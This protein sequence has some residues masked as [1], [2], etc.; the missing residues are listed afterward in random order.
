MFTVKTIDFPGYKNLKNNFNIYKDIFLN[1]QIIAFRNANIDFNMQTQIMNLLGDNL[2]WYP[3]SY[4]QNPSDYIEDH[5]KHMN[6]NNIATKNSIMLGWHQE[7]VASNNGA[8]VSGLWNMTLFN[9]SPDTGKTYFVDMAKFYKN[10]PEEDK[11]FLN[12]C[13]A[14]VKLEDNFVLYDL[15]SLHWITGERVLRTYFDNEVIELFEVDGKSPSNLEIIKFN[16]LCKH[17][18]SEINFNENIRMQHIWQKGDLLITDLFKLAHAVSGGFNK[19]ERKLEG[20]FGK[21]EPW[22][23]L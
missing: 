20:M 5:H 6:S 7:H 16:S 11:F 13:R 9:C 3:N 22:N 18:S 4:I 19:N 1:E 15:V 14:K 8:F 23:R 10:L 2:N 12:K 17:I 21:L